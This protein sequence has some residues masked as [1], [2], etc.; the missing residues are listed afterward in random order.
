MIRL[1]YGRMLQDGLDGTHGLPRARL[2]ELAAGSA[3][4][5]PRSAVAAPPASTGST[6]WSIRARRCGR[7]RSSPR[8]WARRTTTCSCSASAARRSARGRCS[9]RS[10]GRPGTSGTTR[11]ASSS[12]GSPYWRTSI[13]RRWRRRSA[14]SIR[15]GCSSTSSAS[16]AGPRRRWPSISWCAP[17]WRR[18]WARRP[19]AISSSPP[20]PSAARSAR[21]PTEDGIATLSVPTDVGGRFSVLSPVGLLPAALVGI[22][23]AALLAG[24][25]RAVERA[26]SRRPAG[27][28]RPRSTPRSTGRPTPT[29]APASTCSCRTPTG[30]GSSP[31]GTGSSGPRAWASGWIATGDG[32]HRAHTGRRHRR[33]RPAQP[34]AALHGRAVRQGHHLRRRSTIWART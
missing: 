29:S 34:G 28:I 11:A 4:C 22:D 1:A 33:H 3:R 20:I 9:T 10:A 12:R 23:I 19:T 25:R 32:P 30:C 8:D 24:R 5:R 31:S 21:S 13:R 14:G 18:R 7:S 2:A 6:S 27:R 26:E 15:A 17:G 16:R